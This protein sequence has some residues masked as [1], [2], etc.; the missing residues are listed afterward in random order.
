MNRG[1]LFFQLF[2]LYW[3]AFW[4][5]PT[6]AGQSLPVDPE[7]G[8]DQGLVNISYP[9]PSPKASPMVNRLTSVTDLRPFSLKN[10]C[11]LA[12]TLTFMLCLAK[13]EFIKVKS[14]EEAKAHRKKNLSEEQ[15]EGTGTALDGLQTQ[16]G[17]QEDPKALIQKEID[18]MLLKQ[19]GLKREKEASEEELQKALIVSKAFAGEV[20]ETVTRW[21][22][23]L[24]K[25]E[26]A[27]TTELE[28]VVSLLRTSAAANAMLRF[29]REQTS[30]Q[31]LGSINKESFFD[32][33]FRS[34]TLLAESA[35]DIECFDPVLSDM[36]FEAAERFSN[37]VEKFR[38]PTMTKKQDLLDA[39]SMLLK[40]ALTRLEPPSSY[41]VILKKNL[42]LIR[43]ASADI[44][45][46]S[47][48][49][50]NRRLQIAGNSLKEIA[51]EMCGKCD[52]TTI[53]KVQASAVLVELVISSLENEFENKEGAN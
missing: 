52:V 37:L 48:E 45:F 41:T 3:G 24:E 5:V 15:D 11:V 6:A 36:S 51:Q 19:A 4:A 42:Y 49:A 8:I 10:I 14:A 46:D 29:A 2:V 17:S 22:E 23:H 33:L 27:S 18:A 21:L 12:V 38:R 53:A 43:Y 1:G 31:P 9:Q 44:T 39:S 13:T 34:T 7:V 20:N 26:S 47:T 50:C 32:M 16:G 30:F 28:K 25:M 40:E 35:D